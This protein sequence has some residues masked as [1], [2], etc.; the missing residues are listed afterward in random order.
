MSTDDSSRIFAKYYSPPH[1]PTGAAAN[2][3]NY[4]GANPYP[5]VKDQKAFEKG[6]M[7][8]TNKQANDIVLYDNRVVVFK[9]E[10][11]VMLYVIGGAEENEVLLYN[12]VVAL[13]DALA[14]LLGGSTDK[15][16]FIENYD[17]VSLTIDEIVDDG[18][19]LEIDPVV[20]VSRVSKTP[21][22]DA[23]NMKSID[24]SEQGLLNA[25]EFVAHSAKVICRELS[26]TLVGLRV[27]N[28]YD[29]SSRIFLF[30]VAKP[31]VR[32]QLVIDS[33]FRCHLTDYSRATAPSPSHFVSRLRELLKSRRITA[34]SQVGTDR[35]VHIELSDGSLHLFLE[36]FASGNI[37]LT[38]G[39]FKILTL[40]R[41]VAEGEEQDEVRIGLKYRLDNKQ[42]YSGV[43]PLSITRLKDAL[44][45]A[46]DRDNF[47][48]DAT[49][50]R[51]KR[52][53]GEALRRALSLGFPEYPPSLLEHALHVTGF[54]S[55]LRPDQI[56]A[57]D[58]NI[59]GV[60][61]LLEEAKAISAELSTTGKTQGYILKRNQAPQTETPVF[62][63]EI[64]KEKSN[65]FE[66][67]PFEPKQ[68][69]DD[70]DVSVL[71]FDSFN[72]AVDEFYSSV[73][74]QKL[75]SRLTEREETM[76]RKLEATKRD[77]EKR[78]GA[79]KE[80]QQLHTRKA[81]AIEAN[82][83][84]V[85]E[86]IQAVNSLIAQGM[87]WVEIARLI[88]ME[89][90]RHN[91]IAKMIKL[92]LK[93]YENT[94][95][96]LLP[97]D[98]FEPE[99][100]SDDDGEESNDEGEEET[101]KSEILS[102]DIDLGITPWANARQYY[103]QKKSAAVKEDKT[104]KASKKALKSAEK[105]ITADLN[106]G[107]KNEKPVLRPA[108]VPFWYEKF[109]FFIS[110]DGYLVLGGCDKR[111]DEIL[112]YRHL[113]KGD[114]YVHT[115]IEDAIPMIVKNKPGASEAPIPP[116]TLAQAGTFSVATSKAWNS[117]ALM[118][119]W[120]VNSDQV[121]KTTTSGEYLETGGVIIRGEK[122]H[123]PPGQLIIGFAVM[124]QVSAK[125]VIN[126]GRHR[127]QEFE[128]AVQIPEGQT[129][130]RAASNCDY[131]PSKDAATIDIT[132]KQTDLDKLKSATQLSEKQVSEKLAP[133]ENEVQGDVA[134]S[135]SATDS[136]L[137]PQLPQPPIIPEVVEQDLTQESLILE[138]DT[139]PSGTEVVNN[140]DDVM[141]LPSRASSTV[142]T[143]TSTSKPQPQV[144]GKRGKA[145]KLASKYKDQD[146][147]DRELALRMLGS[148]KTAPPK[149]TKE[150]RDAEVQAQK[151]R[152]RAQH[153]RAAQAERQRQEKLKAQQERLKNG[154]DNK[155][156]EDHVDDLSSLPSLIGTPVVG[157]E[158][159][160]ALPVCA[161][162]SALGQC[163]YR[164][165]LQPGTVGKGKTV[166]EVLGRW[167]LSASAVTKAKKV[168]APL[169]VE[170]DPM[171]NEM[172][173]HEEAKT[174]ENEQLTLTATELELLRGWRE[175]EIINTLPVGKVR[176]VS[177]AGAG[178][179]ASGAVDDKNKGKKTSS[180]GGKGGKG[181]KS[182]KKR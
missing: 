73:E 49:T 111:Q 14:I 87:D 83:S 55:S 124:F 68:F 120:W 40:F 62:G 140:G 148:P 153:D 171:Q 5:T 41:V 177:I 1:P 63:G 27:S 169:T 20:V 141:S 112:Y 117:K 35:I 94:I 101:P 39:D 176:I 168:P 38:D 65:Y 180:A 44:Q 60:M 139:M 182:G 132:A 125:S 110:S 134:P 50:K 7:E 18:V 76:K 88:E 102:V 36:F 16:T 118:G 123:L 181:S 53:Q 33:G 91:P 46:K 145:K 70:N 154:L 156:M 98:G 161:P 11:D 147:E 136:P 74:A 150:D 104:I 167:I 178:G 138:E 175:A 19:I 127:Q 9:M 25:W 42:N 8:K 159:I 32:K 163:K 57:T 90:G 89:Q 126:H 100:E 149:K 105:K 115:D 22:P 173:D 34:V 129:A 146:D 114:V 75:E 78:V 59:E 133:F 164:A 95:T 10:S 12:V 109:I 15:R 52:K 67:H 77:H 24:L 82:L 144:R 122:N 113:Q 21:A 79:L 69:V 31:D 158:L 137:D 48:G 106:Q 155:S 152:R 108:R 165:K 170:V 143:A 151:D 54:D 43:P 71:H 66:Y 128:Q 93:L 28:I 29:L 107:L 2:S 13:R 121:S 135:S 6:L 72:K 86:A 96:L 116:G 160:S 174:K 3:L 56:L 119:A 142:H 97:E 64:G 61:H 17:L 84:R 85:E 23:P 130:L 157:D 4:P 80:V 103:D 26:T 92:P 30:K 37:I 162:W 47:Q 81:E 179:N 99:N 45:K 172:Q 51:A 166:K 131:S 58:G